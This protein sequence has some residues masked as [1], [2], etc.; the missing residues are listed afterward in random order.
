MVIPFDLAASFVLEVE[1]CHLSSYSELIAS[2]VGSCVVIE[3]LV[4]LKHSFF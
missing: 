1:S 2:L 4:A 3:R